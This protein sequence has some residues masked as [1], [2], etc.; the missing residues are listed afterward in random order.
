MSSSPLSLFAGALLV[1]VG[2]AMGGYFIGDGISLRSKG[3]NTVSVKGLSEQ[4]VAA[5]VAIWTLNYSA[6]G[7]T[8][9]EIN[10]ALSASTTAVQEFLKTAGFEDKDMAV[11]PP[12][13]AD[14]SLNARDKDDPPLTVRFS[15]SQSVLLRTANVDAVKPAVARTSQLMLKGVLLNGRNEPAYLF[16]KLNDIKPGMIQLAT[17]NARIAATQFAT[18]SQVELGKLRT[19]SQGWFQVE[20]RDAATPERKVVRVIVEVQYEVN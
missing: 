14:L 8:L 13:V 17:K 15:A 12:Y 3:S 19:A 20:D 18:D 6:T 11:Q 2:I 9:D 7:N 10:A 5:S 1:A 16:D 4:E